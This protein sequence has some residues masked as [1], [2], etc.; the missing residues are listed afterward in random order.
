MQINSFKKFFIDFNER[1]EGVGEEH[2]TVVPL[3]YAFTG[4]FLYMPQPGI[5]PCSLGRLEQRSNQVSY[6]VRANSFF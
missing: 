5:Q 3:I 2:W 4:W 1:E 6:L